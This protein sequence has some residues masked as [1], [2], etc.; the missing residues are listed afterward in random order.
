MALSEAILDSEQIF[1][2]ISNNHISVLSP[3]KHP[4]Y[5]QMLPKH[6]VAAL[7]IPN[8]LF[9]LWSDLKSMEHQHSISAYKYLDLVT[10]SL[11]DDN[12]AQN[13]DLLSSANTLE[14]RLRKEC[15][16]ICKK[17]RWQAQGRFHVNHG[18][19]K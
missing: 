1:R 2:E 4:L 14:T 15:S 17:L 13:L 8:K 10:K 19:S 7:Q 12:S 18:V 3:D 6:P 5:R 16:R 9:L 11:Q